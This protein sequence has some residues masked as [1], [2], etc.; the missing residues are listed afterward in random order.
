MQF[1]TFEQAIDGQR[2]R[3]D[4]MSESD[5]ALLMPDH[6]KLKMFL[7]EKSVPETFAPYQGVEFVP[8]DLDDLEVTQQIEAPLRA[9]IA[10]KTAKARTAFLLSGGIDST[11]LVVL[12]T[13]LMN[14]VVCY[15]AVTGAGSDLDHARKIARQLNVTLVEVEVPYDERTLARHRRTMARS[16]NLLPLNG[17]FVGVSAIAEQARA[18][19]FEV[20]I[21][22]TGGGEVY[23]GSV[24]MQ[25]PSWVRAMRDAGQ[26][27]RVEQLERWVGHRQARKICAAA[28]DAPDFRTQQL[29]M[30]KTWMPRWTLQLQAISQTMD[31]DIHSPMIETNALGYA[32]NDPEV[33][34]RGGIPKYQ[35]REILAR[36]L[37]SDLAMRR[38]NQGLR[39]PIGEFLK[40][41]GGEMRAVVRRNLHAMPVW[42]KTYALFR[43]FNGRGTFIRAY[44][45]AVF[46]EELPG[47]RRSARILGG[48]HAD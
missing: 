13:E 11:A 18:D 37:S 31:I 19:G 4:R 9:N 46:L 24:A 8:P 40:Q 27:Q 17:N 5:P 36:R 42:P 1:G 21:D 48:A 25:G 26:L 16:G 14:D 6:D 28:S 47:R 29:Y 12:A 44:A 30:L 32:L 43:A 10:A 7:R 22:G 23:G 20:L 3:L 34:F 2:L 45:V 39:A 33:F 38:D 15:T 35:L 41:C